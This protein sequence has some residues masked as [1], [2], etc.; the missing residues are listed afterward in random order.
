MNCQIL[1]KQ[2]IIYIT[3]SYFELVMRLFIYYWDDIYE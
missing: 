1:Y 2:V 3:N